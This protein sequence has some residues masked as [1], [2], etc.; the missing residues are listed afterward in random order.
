MVCNKIYTI[1]L[2]NDL[3][4]GGG[5]D[6]KGQVLVKWKSQ[7]CRDKVGPT[8][9]IFGMTEQFILVG[10]ITNNGLLWRTLSNTVIDNIWLFQRQNFFILNNSLTLSNKKSK[11]K[12]QNQRYMKHP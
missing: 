2:A 3:S 11:T 5:M 7:V 8:S 6:N 12:E 10:Q 4:M 9:G 1:K